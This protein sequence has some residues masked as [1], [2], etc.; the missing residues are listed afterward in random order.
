MH[1]SPPCQPWSASGKGHGRRDARDGMP[2]M[3]R[4]VEA[5]RPLL[6]TVENVEGLTYRKHRDYLDWFVGELVKLG[7]MVD[8]RVLNAADYGVPQTRKRLMVVGRLEGEVRWPRTTHA[9]EPAGDR[10]PW[11]SMASA[12][13]W[14]LDSP[15]RTVCGNREPRWAF[16]VANSYGTGRTLVGFPRRADGRDEGIVV[17]GEAYRARDLFDA[18]GPSQTVTEKGRSWNAYVLHTNTDQRDGRRQTR[19]VD[20]P[21]P[22]ITAKSGGQWVLQPG[23]F[24]D[25]R[26]GGVGKHRI[27]EPDLEPA[28][29]V[30]LGK[31]V[32]GW[33]WRRPATTVSGDTR[34]HPPGHRQNAAADG[35]KRAGPDAY[36]L[37]VD[38]L[39]VLQDMPRG[40][41]WV[42]T[43]TSAVRQ[44]GNLLPPTMLAAVIGANLWPP[45]WPVD[46]TL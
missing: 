23:S 1:G 12:L 4:A 35:H 19:S 38:E 44:I 16:E 8:W 2:W 36:R 18:S 43:K 25:G 26:S 24:A 21:T 46:T 42:G 6:V 5:L 14:G 7:Y 34:V 33:V 29:T 45:R 37:S 28:P 40:Y 22:T 32:A 39:A 30:A 41:P 15:T 3:L 31:D 11:V 13:G 27:Y 17:N 10:E 20:M 9:K